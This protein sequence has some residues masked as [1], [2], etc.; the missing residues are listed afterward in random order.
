MEVVTSTKKILKK[1]SS[2]LTDM[3]QVLVFIPN[4]FQM[5]HFLFALDTDKIPA[6]T[7]TLVSGVLPRQTSSVEHVAITNT[8]LFLSIIATEKHVAIALGTLWL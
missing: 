4:V 8:V 2:E 1:H 5:F 7:L 6:I 3:A